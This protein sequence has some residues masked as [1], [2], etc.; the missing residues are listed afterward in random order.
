MAKRIIDTQPKGG[1]SCI[2]ISSIL[3]QEIFGEKVGIQFQSNDVEN[4]QFPLFVKKIAF[5]VL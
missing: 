2:C 5:L 1:Y 3:F 4:F